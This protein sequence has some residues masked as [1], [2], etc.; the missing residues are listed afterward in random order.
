MNSKVNYVKNKS[1]IIISGPSGVGKD[2]V[3]N[4]IQSVDS[5]ISL[6]IS[7]TT[8][9][10]RLGEKDGVNYH[11]LSR[12]NFEKKIANSEFLEYTD[13]SGIYYGTLKKTI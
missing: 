4:R 5:K 1:L 2:S 9:K 11:F 3:I 6:A 10:M 7:V 8:R 13:Y 12:E